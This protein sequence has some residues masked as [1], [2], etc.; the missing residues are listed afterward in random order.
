[1]KLIQ[2]LRVNK[3]FGLDSGLDG[4]DR[5]QIWMVEL[6]DKYREVGLKKGWCL[7]GEGRFV[8]GQWKKGKE[9]CV[10]LECGLQ[11]LVIR[12]LNLEIFYDLVKGF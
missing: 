4:M 6:F 11:F 1:M 10:G 8:V 2:I 9:Y 7:R 5:G 12:Y 3:L